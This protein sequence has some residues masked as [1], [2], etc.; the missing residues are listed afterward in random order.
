MVEGDSEVK[1]LLCL[2]VLATATPSGNI[3]LLGGV[4][5]GALVQLHFK[6]ILRVKTLDSFGS[7]D[8]TILSV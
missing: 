3:H 4:A 8:V 1:A 6:G 7:D 5:I 2:P